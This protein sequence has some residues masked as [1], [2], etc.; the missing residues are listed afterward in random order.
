MKRMRSYRTQT[1]RGKLFV[2][3][4]TLIVRAYLLKQL[5][6]YMRKNNLTL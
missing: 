1:A 3:F 4:F 2:S 5:K 6:D